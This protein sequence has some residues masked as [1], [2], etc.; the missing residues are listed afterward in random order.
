MLSI[1]PASSRNTQNNE[2]GLKVQ[3]QKKEGQLHV[4]FEKRRVSCCVLMVNVI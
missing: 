1:P 2:I 4:P 3:G